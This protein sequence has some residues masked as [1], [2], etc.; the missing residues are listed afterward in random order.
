MRTLTLIFM[1]LVFAASVSAVEPYLPSDAERAR[2]TMSDLL[3][4]QI[5][6]DAYK[7][8]YNHF[9]AG[10]VDQVRTVLEPVYIT[11]LPLTDAWG[12]PYRIESDG[13]SYRIVSAGSDGRFDETTWNEPAKHLPYDADAIL[14]SGTQGLTRAWKYR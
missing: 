11:H 12:H 8:D 3:T 1:A 4:W 7:T 10:A 13:K 2:W 5:C 14:A 6:L 9:P